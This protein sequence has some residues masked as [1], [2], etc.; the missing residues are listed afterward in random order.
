MIMW[1]ER[2]SMEFNTSFH[3]YDPEHGKH[4]VYTGGDTFSEISYRENT[5]TERTLL[6][7]EV[8][9]VKQKFLP[10][11]TVMIRELTNKVM[12]K[13]HGAPLRIFDIYGIGIHN[14]PTRVFSKIKDEDL[15]TS[16]IH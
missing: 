7:T 11:P 15:C 1:S 6:N 10:E 16:H 4:F 13:R 5:V 12:I 8:R 14:S 2:L 9:R 3:I